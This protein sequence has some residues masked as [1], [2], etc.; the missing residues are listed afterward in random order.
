MTFTKFAFVAVCALFSSSVLAA[1]GSVKF[2]IESLVIED[3]QLV[4]VPYVE[5]NIFLDGNH[6]YGSGVI[7]ARTDENG[8]AVLELEEGEHT[9]IFSKWTSS[10]SVFASAVYTFSVAA[11]EQT[12]VYESLVTTRATIIATANT[13][14]GNA[15]YITGD[16]ELLGNWQ[17]AYRLNPMSASEWTYFAHLPRGI[18]YKIVLAP[19]VDGVE[20]V[21]TT[22]VQWQYGANNAVQFVEYMNNL[23][24][25][26]F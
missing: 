15:L 25:P 24:S 4:G 11:G 18:E 16:T 10:H 2:N 22:N 14:W 6:P 3:R 8:E 20:E 12:E 17:T 21:S 19:W 23:V 1:T 5:A 26:Q 9:V 13:G 7:A